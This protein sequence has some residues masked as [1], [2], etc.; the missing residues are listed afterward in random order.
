[1]MV[2][3]CNAWGCDVSPVISALVLGLCGGVERSPALG[4]RLHQMLLQHS[5]GARRRQRC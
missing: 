5:V 4:T 2:V 3:G 1:M